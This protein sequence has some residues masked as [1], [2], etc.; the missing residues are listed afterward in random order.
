MTA[1]PCRHRDRKPG[2]ADSPRRT[3]GPLPEGNT[4]GDAGRHSRGGR[5]TCSAHETTRLVGLSRD[6]LHDQMRRSNLAGVKAGR[7]RPLTC[8][9][10]LFPGIAS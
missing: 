1:Q 9:H 8:Q 7:W 10:Q 2:R 3:S 5:L 6:L 4:A